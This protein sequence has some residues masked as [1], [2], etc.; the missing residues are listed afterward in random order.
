MKKLAVILMVAGWAALLTALDFGSFIGQK[1][2]LW[3]LDAAA[4]EEKYPKYFKFVD[5]TN[6]AMRFNG[7]GRKALYLTLGDAD[8]YEIIINLKDQKIRKISMSLYNRGDA[9]KW[10][11]EKFK[12]ALEDAR[13]KIVEMVGKNVVPVERNDRLSG[14]KVNMANYSTPDMDMVLRWSGASNANREPEYIYIDVYY[15]GEGPRDLRKDL[16]IEVVAK[17]LEK[18]IKNDELGRYLDIPMVDQG[19]KGYC[20]AAAVERM[21]RYY[22]S[23]VDQ[24]TIAQVA[25]S[26][27]DRG[28]SI[29]KTLETLGKLENKFG[30]KTKLCYGFEEFDQPGSFGEFVNNYN[31]LA[32]QAKKQ[33]LKLENYQGA[34]GRYFPDK[35]VSATDMELFIQTRQREKSDYKKFIE[36][37][38]EKI[39]AGLPVLWGTYVFPGQDGAAKLGRHMR[40]INGYN[41]KESSLIY[42]DSW[43]AGHEHKKMKYEDAYGI[44]TVVIG[45]EPKKIK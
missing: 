33:Q 34:K 4:V 2:A 28:T 24:H 27:A 23:N 32:K 5:D 39:D 12:K 10:T 16:K 38:H 25:D 45:L 19:D 15:P 6:Q 26:D 17:G 36:T 9:G 37:I 43:G 3:D 7:S 35:F 18:N 8:I 20:V 30:I 14:E 41:D 11:E 44:T 29:V 40:I 31:R 21:M 13:A 42:T 22:G 1:K